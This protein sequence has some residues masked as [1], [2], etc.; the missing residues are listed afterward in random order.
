M[1]VLAILVLAFV[2]CDAM[3]KRFVSYEEHVY[4]GGLPLP[5]S[6]RGLYN[7]Y[8]ESNSSRIVGGVAAVAGDAKWIVS[9]KRTASGSHFCGGS[10]YNAKTII[11]AAHCISG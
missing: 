5:E 1:K 11:T 4:N 3:P 8:V 7:P 6:L 10:I 2:A 9:L